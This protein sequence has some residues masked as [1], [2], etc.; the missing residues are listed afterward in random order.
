MGS[1]H[2]IRI[3]QTASTLDLRWAKMNFLEPFSVSMTISASKNWA[4]SF[5]N[6]H[7]CVLLY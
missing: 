2:S 5:I 4:A 6:K 1:I 7:D 3:Q